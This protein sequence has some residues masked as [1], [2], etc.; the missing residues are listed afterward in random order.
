M[1]TTDVARMPTFGTH[2]RSC[3]DKDR[4]TEAFS[5]GYIGCTHAAGQ[6]AG[7][8]TSWCRRRCITSGTQ[9]ESD[10]HQHGS[11]SIPLV[12]QGSTDALSQSDPFSSEG[13][14]PMPVSLSADASGEPWGSTNT[15]PSNMCTPSSS[16]QDAEW[17]RPPQHP[18][19]AT[20]DPSQVGP[21]LVWPL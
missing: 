8:L 7:A 12:L 16:S 6:Y 5:F 1:L 11:D 4:H 18:E 20:D 21:P 17:G 13:S 19:K 2:V 10:I 9:C 3:I 15:Q 14:A